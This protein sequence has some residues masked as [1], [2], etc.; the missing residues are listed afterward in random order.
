[1]SKSM[2]FKQI[3]DLGRSTAKLAMAA[4]AFM[5]LGFLISFAGAPSLGNPILLSGVLGFVLAILGF[6]HL[7]SLQEKKVEQFIRQ[8]RNGDRLMGLC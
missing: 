8:Y 6:R 1:M 4:F 3:D 5:F 7:I 2:T